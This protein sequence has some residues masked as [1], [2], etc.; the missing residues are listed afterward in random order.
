VDIVN[1]LGGELVGVA[2]LCDRSNGKLNLGVRTEALM[3][4]TIAAFKPEECPQCR[5]GKPLTER[6]SRNL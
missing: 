6:G 3:T 1:N 2:L 5:E 4:L